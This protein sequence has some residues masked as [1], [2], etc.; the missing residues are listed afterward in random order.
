MFSEHHFFTQHGSSTVAGME[1]QTPNVFRNQDPQHGNRVLKPD[2]TGQEK[3][4]ADQFVK[5]E[6]RLPIMDDRTLFNKAS[7]PA[8]CRPS[9]GTGVKGFLLSW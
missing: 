1:N 8:R 2:A 7:E 4:H 5:L 9:A 6:R 3:N